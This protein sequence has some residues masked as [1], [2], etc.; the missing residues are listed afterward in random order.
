MRNRIVLLG[1][2]LAI[3][4]AAGSAQAQKPFSFGIAGGVSMPQGNYGDIAGNG[5]HATAALGLGLPLVPVGLRIE[6]SYNRFALSDEMKAVVGE[7]G[8]WSLASATANLTYSLPLP[9]VVVSPYVIAGAG[10]YMGNCSMDNCDSQ[11]D[12]GYNAGVGL[13]F[14]ALVFSAFAEARYH[15]VQTEGESTSYM[16]ITIGFMF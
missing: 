7:S 9:A 8:S 15:S 13:K 14:K 6:G 2:T 3:A 16:P 5:Y 11:S 12:L 10:M 4:L 1:S